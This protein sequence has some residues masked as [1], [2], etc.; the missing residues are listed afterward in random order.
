MSLRPELERSTNQERRSFIKEIY[1]NLKKYK[2][3]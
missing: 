1:K 2:K 3:N